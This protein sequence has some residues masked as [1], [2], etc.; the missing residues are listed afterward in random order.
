[1]LRE[2]WILRLD[3]GII[4]GRY[5]IFFIF[6]FLFFLFGTPEKKKKMIDDGFWVGY[7]CGS[8]GL[9]TMVSVFFF[10]I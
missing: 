5:K 4:S 2:R 6:L 7:Y 10:F 8:F 1:M 3:I 9:S